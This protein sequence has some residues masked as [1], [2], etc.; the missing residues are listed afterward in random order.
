[1]TGA[2]DDYVR[3]ERLLLLHH[4]GDRYLVPP[5]PGERYLPPPDRYLPPPAP[6]P[7]DHWAPPSPP[8]PAP[9]ER[10]VPPLSPSGYDRYDRYDRYRDRYYDYISPQ[11]PN[12]HERYL[13]GTLDRYDRFQNNVVSTTPGGPGDPYMRRDLGYHHHYR[14]PPPPGFYHPVY[15]RTPNH[16]HHNAGYAT[17]RHHRHTRCC[18]GMYPQGN[19]REGNSGGGSARDYVTSPVLPRGRTCR[20]GSSGSGSTPV[21]YVG[22]SGGRYV[23]TTPPLPRCA[24][25]SDVKDQCGGSRRGC[26]MA[27]CCNAR[28]P[29]PPQTTQLLTPHHNSVWRAVGQS[30]P[31]PT[32]P[33]TTQP[34]SLPTLTTPSTSPSAQMESSPHPFMRSVSAPTAPLPP[35][36]DPPTPTGAPGATCGDP[37]EAAEA[38]EQVAPLQPPVSLRLQPP[39]RRPLLHQASAPVTQAEMRRVHLTRTELVKDFIKREAAVFLGVDKETE[40]RERARWLER[41]KRLCTRK[42]G[43]KPEHCQTPRPTDSA[44]GGKDEGEDAPKWT[45][46][47]VRRKPSVAKMT[48]KGMALVVQTLGRH[49]GTHPSQLSRQMSRSYS[50]STVPATPD[51]SSPLEDEVFY[52]QPSLTDPSSAPVITADSVTDSPHPADRFT[53]AI[54]PEE[55]LP[56][57]R[58]HRLSSWKRQDKQQDLVAVGQVGLNR[59]YNHTLDGVLDNS[60]RRQYG[61]GIVG[62][63]FG[64]S[65]KRSV[66]NREP[67]KE[68]LED[69]EDHRPFFTYWVTTVQILILFFSLFC[70]G[71]GPIGIDLHQESGLVLVTSLSLQQV[72]FSEPANF[73][74]GPRAADL[75]HLGAK[76]APCM[77]KDAKIIKEIE[78]G[79]EKERE[80]AC[81]IRNDDSGCVQSSQADCSITHHG[82]LIQH[83]RPTVKIEKTIS[84]WKK[85]SP[86]DSGP[87][88]RI[89]GTVC[90]LDPKFCEAPASVAPYEWPDDI[91]KW[92]ICRKTFTGSERRLR[93]RQKDR[94]TAEHMVCEVIG[95][96]CCIGIHGSCRITTREYCDFVHGYFHE[97]ASLCS[98][99]SCL[100]N[101]CGM[102]PFYSPEVPDQFYRLWTSLFLHA[103][104]IHLA[105]TLVLQWFMMR[106]LEKLTGSL[107]IMI[108]YMGSGVGGNLASAIFV[109]YRAD[110]GPAG[111]QFGLLACLIVEVLNSWQM[112]KSPHHALLKLVSIVLFLFVFGLLPWVDNFAH[113]FGFIFGF[114]LSFA[115]LPFVSFGEYDRQK[116]IF[117]IW[118]CLMTCV[119][120]FLTLLLLFYITPIYDCQIC[121]FFN[122]LPLTDHFCS[123]QNINF[124]REV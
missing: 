40:A 68:Q 15:Q 106:D 17:M 94:L 80:T 5:A 59:I 96:P 91:T 26:E 124:K 9:N 85:W 111:A 53:P 19:T 33:P 71:F 56:Q 120:L 39:R 25:V 22:S 93:E 116:K 32:P 70:Y 46:P 109:P 101:V 98:Q 54:V 7:S 47:P 90:G 66:T 21:E 3:R 18:P 10:Y 30:P 60:D 88:G 42:Y 35:P 34:P 45:E 1:M 107:R 11:S 82:D 13:C 44:D 81:C 79:R 37:E 12:Y 64:R 6:A 102:I 76:F 84:T 95:H 100:D 123:A 57:Q 55:V 61:M 121:S 105:I 104:V 113:L 77:R 97:E 87:G 83:L 31:S 99:V 2:D 75:I 50:P 117:L 72:E 49:R 67:V 41:R 23:S 14:L 110:V 114:L 74:I 119:F 27:L 73:W 36:S 63:L 58:M 65:L 108:I 28:R 69:L 112:L 20:S 8:A 29:T 48:F 89:S 4:G 115:L 118:V 78:K 43:L 52:D 122:C 86:G 16:S 51:P 92:P 24:S 62:R 103:G 38:A